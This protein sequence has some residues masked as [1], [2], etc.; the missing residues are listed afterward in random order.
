[1]INV[2][3]ENNRHITALKKHG[4]EAVTSSYLHPD[5]HDNAAP[6]SPSAVRKT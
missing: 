2:A 1:L 5:G 4:L 6:W 3:A